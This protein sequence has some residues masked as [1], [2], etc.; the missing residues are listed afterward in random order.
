M[1]IERS[2]EINTSAAAAW[3]VLGEQFADVSEWAD[4]IV[5]SSLDG[6][7]DRGV[8]RTCHIK[9][10][11]PIA[12]GEIK[13]KLTHFNRDSRS[14]TYLVLSGTPNV[15]DSIENAWTIEDTGNDRC[16]VTSRITFSMKWWALPL[17]PLMFIPL[18]QAVR[19]FLGQLKRR[20]EVVH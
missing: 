19:D 13:E 17:A 5:K 15:M 12:A 7:L 4:S 3:E 20:V 10:V 1:L 6:P 8:V 9:A 18:G 2:I 16:T 14:L 11:G